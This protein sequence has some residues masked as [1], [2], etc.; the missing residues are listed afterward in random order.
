MI[1]NLPN[2]QIHIRELSGSDRSCGVVSQKRSVNDR[3]ESLVQGAITAQTVRNVVDLK[4]DVMRMFL[5]R[6]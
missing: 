3:V 2:N 5:Q 4:R 6:S 1:H